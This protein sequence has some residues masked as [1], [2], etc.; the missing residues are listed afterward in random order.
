WQALGHETAV[1]DTSWPNVDDSA[2]VQ[3]TLELIVQVN[4]KVRG[5]VQVSASASEDEIKAAALANE[6]VLKFTEGTSIQ[7]VIVVKGRLVNIV[8]A[9]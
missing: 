3:N 2:L 7:K 5:K 9:A 8:V 6:N 4:G 1:I